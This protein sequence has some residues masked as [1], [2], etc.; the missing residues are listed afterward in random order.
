LYGVLGDDTGNFYIMGPIAV[1]YLIS[2]QLHD[3][4]SAHGI[5][6]KDLFIPY[7]NIDCM[8]NIM[9]IANTMINGTMLSE[10]EILSYSIKTMKQVKPDEED[11]MRYKLKKIKEQPNHI[12]YA[13][14]RL[15]TD[16]VKNADLEMLDKI[17]HN[18]DEG[19]LGKL[20]E[21]RRR[22]FHMKKHMAA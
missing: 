14:E 5:K 12:S 9:V 19:R 13:E 2:A 16:A 6:G 1:D 11:D 20:A 8:L 18:M 21:N 3:Y 17:K 10:E 7:I 15:F 22:R 4:R